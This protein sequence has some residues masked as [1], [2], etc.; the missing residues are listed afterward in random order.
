MKLRPAKCI[1]CII[2]A[3]FLLTAP[4]TAHAKPKAPVLTFPSHSRTVPVKIPFKKPCPSK[5]DQWGRLGGASNLFGRTPLRYNDCDEDGFDSVRDGG[6]DC[7]DYDARV[8]PGVTETCDT[9]DNNCNGTTDEGVT[10]ACGTCGVVPVEICD[11]LDNDCNGPADDE[12]PTYTWYADTDDDG[13]GNPAASTSTCASSAPAGYVANTD[14]CDDTN[15]AIHPG[16]VEVCDNADN[17][18]AGGVDN[19]IAPIPA[20]NIAGSCEENIKICEHGVFENAPTNYNPTAETCDGLD[21]DCVAGIDNGLTNRPASN[22]QG[23]CAGNMESCEGS[24]G[25]QALVT[26]YTPSSEICD[27][28]D[29]DCAGGVDNGLA[30]R[31]TTNQQGPCSGDIENCEGTAGWQPDGLNHIKTTEICDGFDNDC[32]NGIDDELADRPASNTQG[33]CAG[34]MESCE[35]T[36][37]YQPKATNYTPTAEQCD[38]LDNDCASGVDDGMVDR[39]ASNTQGLCSG[40]T[41]TC[42]GIDGWQATATNYTPTA[43][44]CDGLDND[45]TGGIDNGLANR[46]AGNTQG[47]CAGNTE[48]C[49]GVDG[50]QASATNYT[51]TAEI[52][53]GV[54]NDCADG[55]DNGL[56]DRLTSNQNGEC[57]GNLEHCEGV[58]GYQPK[59]TNYIPTAEICDELD[60]NCADGIDEGLPLYTW[61][62]DADSDNYGNPDI[63]VTN[64]HSPY[65][66][67]V[68]NSTDCNDA[69]ATV[70]PSVAE[71]TT[72][73]GDENC[74]GQGVGNLSEAN[75]FFDGIQYD[76]MG[77]SMAAVGDITGD[78]VPDTLVGAPG[79]SSGAPY[80]TGYAFILPGNPVNGW[81]SNDYIMISGEI[82]GDWAGS[83]LAYAGDVNDD[84]KGDI[85]IGAQRNSSSTGSAYLLS[86]PITS[87]IELVDADHKWIGKA[88]PDY[89]G[90]VVIPAGDFNGD[91]YNDILIT[92]PVNNDGG[93]DAGQAYLIFGPIADDGSS[94]SLADAD[95]TFTGTG[96]LAYFGGTA[97]AADFN[98]DGFTDIA[99]TS[100]NLSLSAPSHIYIYLGSEDP[101]TTMTPDDADSVITGSS[102]FE[103]GSALFASDSA[104]FDGDGLPDLVIGAR[105]NNCNG[106]DSGAIYIYSNPLT[107]KTLTSVNSYAYICGEYGSELSDSSYA[108]DAA[109]QDGDGDVDLLLGSQ[110]VGK[111][112]LFKGP[113]SG[114][115]NINSGPAHI[116]GAETET[117]A[118][119]GRS[120]KFLGDIDGDGKLEIGIG[121]PYNRKGGAQSGSTYFIFGNRL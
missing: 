72:L 53:D 56:A 117:G 102:S 85:L 22:T 38:G 61:Y 8:H 107:S 114:T 110:N 33:E 121:D 5:R 67:Y 1:L 86:G 10:N 77:F 60:N 2:C 55:I 118:E 65:P 7:N 40:N 13:Y 92:A 57:E 18:C 34:N 28:L 12:L 106:T 16:A 103:F 119:A 51:P 108:I 48:T 39:P 101:S 96:T 93:T 94:T 89:A 111:A 105:Y 100:P 66:S 32:A 70:N 62:K 30:D 24:R 37:G 74:D 81:D 112:Y 35:G 45:C 6:G 50:W 42:N 15:N 29:N 23:A 78:G 25:W 36:A 63:S 11:G 26:N 90:A 83:S 43:E 59:A 115:L 95:V 9:R 99:I 87:A 69:D 54:D 91:G 79:W 88:S 75:A 47:Q 97:A 58:L 82:Y 84:G 41:E 19:G 104:D 49:N 120:T 20:D 71:D 14:D 3:I 109:D 80:G 98:G 64:C 76:Y 17:D 44:I 52:C 116:L 31:L 68:S 46:P 21:N 113:I 27:G 4:L 73:I